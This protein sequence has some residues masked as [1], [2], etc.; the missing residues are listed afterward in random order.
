MGRYCARA[1]AFAL[2][3]GFA[4]IAVGCGG[5]SDNET[6]TTP[7]VKFDLANKVKSGMP[8]AELI[9]FVGNPALTSKPMGGA[10][11]ECL[12]FPMQGRPVAN[13]W[14]F[15]VDEHNKVN[16]GVTE[17]ALDQPPPPQD[18]SVARA[19]LIGRADTICL[20]APQ[21]TGPPEKLVQ[22]I[23]QV[24]ASSPPAARQK[25]AA[26]MRKFSEGAKATR[27]QIDGFNAPPDELSELDA[28]LNALHGQALALDQAAKALS[29]GD[30]KSYRQA[31]D[32]ARQQGQAATDH[33][34]Q[35]GLSTCAGVKLS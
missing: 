4:A 22:Q 1:L 30:E 17:Y 26:L 5:S 13:V 11:G 32:R 29:A 24:T 21:Q 33:A 8:R 23:K 14:M 35:Y 2:L 19:V 10:P 31:L 6:T 3:A 16:A 27:S 9:R 28:Y 20:A 34:R 15:C 7:G 12:Y 25:L 18:A